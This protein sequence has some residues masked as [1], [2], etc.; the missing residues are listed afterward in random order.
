MKQ[1]DCVCHKEESSEWVRIVGVPSLEGWEVQKERHSFGVA[2]QDLKI[3]DGCELLEMQELIDLCNSDL[4][5]ILN[6]KK[7]EKYWQEYVEQP[8]NFNKGKRAAWLGCNGISGYLILD[9]Y[10]YLDDCD[11][12]RGV[13]YKR[14]I[15][16]D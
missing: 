4:A 13:R 11:A 6:L 9:A 2:F 7:T 10:S 3:P 16:S 12:A 5:E 15:G 14:K 1:C 8:F